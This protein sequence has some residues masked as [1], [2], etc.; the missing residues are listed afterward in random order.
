MT[1][2]FDS[3]LNTLLNEYMPIDIVPGY[4]GGGGEVEANFPAKSEGKYALTSDQTK[5]VMEKVIA[6]LRSLNGHSDKTYKDFQEQDIASI[7]RTA[8]KQSGTNSKYAARVIHNALIEAGVI[9]DERNG[10]KLS[11]TA[12]AA[13]DQA[14]D[15]VEKTKTL[16]TSDTETTTPAP[17][18]STEDEDL[19]YYKSGSFDLDDT[20]LEKKWNKLPEGNLEWSQVIKLIGA[21]AAL[22]LLDKDALLSTTRPEEEESEKDFEEGDSGEVSTIEEPAEDETTGVIKRPESFTQSWNRTISPFANSND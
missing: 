15:Q 13:V 19:V 4:T 14:V 18:S 8:A 22:E 7:I 21:T 3:L 16:S 6:H 1:T 20:N 12:P 5:D 2:K 9:T 17:A 11:K 10:T